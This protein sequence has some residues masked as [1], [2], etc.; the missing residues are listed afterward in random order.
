MAFQRATSQSYLYGG[1]TDTAPPADP[2]LTWD[3]TGSA[4]QS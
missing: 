2:T 4:W 3:W 1:Y